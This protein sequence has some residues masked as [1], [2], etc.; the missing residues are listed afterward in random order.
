MVNY[1]IFWP[2]NKTDW[3][4]YVVDELKTHILNVKDLEQKRKYE[5]HL[6]RNHDEIIDYMDKRDKIFYIKNNDGEIISKNV[7]FSEGFRLIS[8]AALQLTT[9][10]LE[11]LDPNDH[12]FF[13]VFQ[14]GLNDFLLAQLKGNSLYADVNLSK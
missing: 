8:A 2:K 6:M 3:Y 9:I 14:N 1:N 12:N 13:I 4:A 5:T 7:T 11:S 10:P